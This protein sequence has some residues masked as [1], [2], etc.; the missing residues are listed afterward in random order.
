MRFSAKLAGAVLAAAFALVS[1]VAPVRAN[2]EVI[3]HGDV[4]L[5]ACD[6][7]SAA[8][9][10]ITQ[11]EDSDLLG[12]GFSDKAASLTNPGT[13]QAGTVFTPDNSNLTASEKAAIQFALANVFVKGTADARR[14]ANLTVCFDGGTT[15]TIPL[16]KCPT[17]EAPLGWTE[18]IFGPRTLGIR[19]EDAKRLERFSV[20]LTGETI[21]KVGNVV[22]YWELPRKGR[23]DLLGRNFYDNLELKLEDC[24][25]LN[26]CN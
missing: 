22:T 18:V 24:T 12:L 15:V 11:A 17:K 26:S 14:H 6:G 13:G 8:Y 20:Y 19:D 2:D 9:I 1:V 3:G 21:L 4:N 25:I 5:G 16:S 7:S 23:H 10:T